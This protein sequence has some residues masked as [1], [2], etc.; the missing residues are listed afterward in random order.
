[1]EPG[2]RLRFCFAFPDLYEIGMSH[3]GLHLM[4]QLLNE[5]DDVF[6]ERC[7]MPW[8]DFR[9]QLIDHAIDLHTLETKTSLRE[10]DFIGFT[11]QYEL[12]F[13]NI[14]EMLRLAHIP[15]FAEERKNGNFPLIVAGGPCVYNPEPI[16]DFIDVFFIGESEELA[17]E[18]LDLARQYRLDDPTEKEAFLIAASKLE[19]IY[20]PR[21]YRPI[22]NEFGDLTGYHKEGD[23]EGTPAPKIRKRIVKDV[24]AC[25]QLTEPIVP[26]SDIVH[27][28]AVAEIFRGCTRGCRFCQAGMIYRPIREKSVDT[29]MAN[30]DALITASGYD[31]VSLSS[32]STLD[33]SRIEELVSRLAETYGSSRTSISLPSLRMDAAAEDMSIRVLNKLQA[34]RKS[35]LTFAPEAGTQRLRDVINKNVT[36]R[37]IEETFRKIFALGWFRVKLYFMIGLPTETELDLKGIEEIGNL[38]VYLFKQVKPEQMKKLAEVTIS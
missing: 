12:S 36:E 28:R 27:D 10:M 16:A 18:F 31:E 20:V 4:Y 9:R 7:F 29:V 33:Y 6:C 21:F 34:V 17:P 11:L 22:Y 8:S 19:G 37:D 25:F 14:L 32:L 2:Q 35:G 5:R 26:F 15:L 24:D 30:I 23:P 13:T 1:K 38:A 3:L